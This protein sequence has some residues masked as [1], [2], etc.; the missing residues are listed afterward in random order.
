MKAKANPKRA[1]ALTPR[2]GPMRKKLLPQAATSRETGE[3]G[4]SSVSIE[5]KS[6]RPPHKNAKRQ[7]ATR[8]E[9]AVKASGFDGNYILGAVIAL[10]AL[11]L[12]G[13]LIVIVL[14][15][16]QAAEAW[17]LIGSI[18]PP[19]IASLLAFLAGRSIRRA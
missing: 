13:A 12:I 14:E 1:A 5:V 16:P 2:H 3:L 11:L 15:K 10:L 7:R 18:F 8:R 9:S 19:T 17:K 6:K 4:G